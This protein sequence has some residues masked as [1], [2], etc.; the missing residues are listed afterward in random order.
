MTCASHLFDFKGQSL[1]HDD[2]NKNNN[3]IGVFVFR[4][5]I[6]DASTPIEIVFDKIQSSLF[7]FVRIVCKTN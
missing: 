7:S 4:I 3:N 6:Y 2:N 5:S 1:T